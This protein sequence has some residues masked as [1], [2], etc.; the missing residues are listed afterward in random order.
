MS[1]GDTYYEAKQRRKVRVDSG[2]VGKFGFS[3]TLGRITSE[4]RL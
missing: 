2:A 3:G 4:Q 1:D